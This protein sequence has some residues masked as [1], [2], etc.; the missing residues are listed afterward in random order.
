MSYYF[1]MLRKLDREISIV[2][3]WRHLY[4]YITTQ[5]QLCCITNFVSCK[6]NIL[7]FFGFNDNVIL[8][9]NGLF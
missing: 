7:G 8:I 3:K 2:M 9:E 6:L 5:N 1:N 4:F